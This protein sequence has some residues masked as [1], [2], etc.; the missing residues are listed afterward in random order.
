MALTLCKPPTIPR[1]KVDQKPS[2]VFV[3]ICADNVYLRAVVHDAVLV[4]VPRQIVIGAVLIGPA[5]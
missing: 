2:I 4:S 3:W 5:S 1:L